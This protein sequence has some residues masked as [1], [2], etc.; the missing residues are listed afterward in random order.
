M[1]FLVGVLTLLVVIAIISVWVFGARY[2][3]EFLPPMAA[4]MWL[5]L[6]IFLLGAIYKLGDVTVDLIKLNR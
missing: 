5:P 1:K 2:L 3:S 6:T 4:T